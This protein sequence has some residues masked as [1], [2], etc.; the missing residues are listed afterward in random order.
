MKR[1]GKTLLSRIKSE[2]FLFF[3]NDCLAIRAEDEEFYLC[4]TLEDVP[5]SKESFNIAWFDVVDKKEQIYEVG[6]N[7]TD[8]DESLV[9]L[10]AVN[11][12]Q[13]RLLML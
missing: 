7:K 8:D 12:A 6:L 9:S 11:L 1:R 13:Q 2:K 4:R 3:A 5:E 10:P